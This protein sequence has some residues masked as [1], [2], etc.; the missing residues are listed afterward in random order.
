MRLTAG[1]PRRAIVRCGTRPASAPRN[2][3]AAAAGTKAQVVTRPRAGRPPRTAERFDWNE[4][5]ISGGR[6]K[7]CSASRARPSTSVSHGDC[8]AWPPSFKTRP[9]SSKATKRILLRCPPGAGLIE[10]HEPALTHLTSTNQFHWRF[11]CRGR[12]H[13]QSRSGIQPGRPPYQIAG[14][15]AADAALSRPAGIDTGGGG[16]G[17]RSK[18]LIP[19][20]EAGAASGPRLPDFNFA[21][22]ARGPT[23]QGGLA[24]GKPSV[25]WYQIHVR[26]IPGW[27]ACRRPQARPARFVQGNNGER[28]LVLSPE[29]AAAMQ[30]RMCHSRMPSTF[31][32]DHRPDASTCHAST[33][34]PHTALTCAGWQWRG[35][36]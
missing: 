19:P 12:C 29:D 7:S 4:Q 30:R 31:N 32:A 28:S 2:R 23:G 6:P 25:P 10:R 17:S 13:V 34:H 35:S 16:G 9:M 20:D 33:H 18:A 11:R 26:G 36:I 8:V 1:R 15:L 5:C 14:S 22:S 24:A 21:K 27:R 3:R